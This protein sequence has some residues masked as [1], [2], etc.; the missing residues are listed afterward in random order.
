MNGTPSNRDN[1]HNIR[2]TTIVAPKIEPTLKNIP[3]TKFSKYR[4][5]RGKTY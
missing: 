5:C 3:R 1:I 2:A 4:R